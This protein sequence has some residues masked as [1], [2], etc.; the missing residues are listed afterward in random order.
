MILNTQ[1]FFRN[2]HMSNLKTEFFEMVEPQMDAP[3]IIPTGSTRT[4]ASKFPLEVQGFANFYLRGPQAA[5]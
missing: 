2:M 3:T 4:S 5:S 1:V